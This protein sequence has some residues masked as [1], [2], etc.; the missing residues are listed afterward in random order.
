MKKIKKGRFYNYGILRLYKDDLI[1]IIKLFQ[2]NFKDVKIIVEDYRLE[3]VKELDT[4]KKDKINN[5]EVSTHDNGYIDI[6]TEFNSVKI[7]ISNDDDI[8][9]QGIYIKLDEILKKRKS[10][11]LHVFSSPITIG[12]YLAPILI[13]IGLFPF[14]QKLW[15]GLILLILI[16]MIILIC[17]YFGLKQESYVYMHESSSHINLFEKNRDLIVGITV[18]IVTTVFGGVILY[19][20][21]NSFKF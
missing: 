11:I 6:K 5:F 13:F 14:K 12:F 9:L 16:I 1:S 18:G 4:I 15:E 2:D 20:I 10:I 17:I 19:I 7:Y 3:N 8:L 21:L